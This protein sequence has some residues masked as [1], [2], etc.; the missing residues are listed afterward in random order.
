M[1]GTIETN[2]TEFGNQVSCPSINVLLFD[3]LAQTLHASG[4]FFRLHL[5]GVT[6][7]LG[8][9]FHVIRIHQHGIAQFTSGTGEAAN[10]LS[11]F[12]FAALGGWLGT[13]VFSLVLKGVGLKAQPQ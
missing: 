12:A 7:G 11:A 8:G 3:H 5:Q 13:E 6:N 4:S 9:L 10:P 2:P 1:A